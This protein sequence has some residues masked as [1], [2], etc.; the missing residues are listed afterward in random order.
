MADQ[1]GIEWPLGF[2]G[3][4]AG[5]Q[6]VSAL[7]RVPRPENFGLTNFVAAVEAMDEQGRREIMTWLRQMMEYYGYDSVTAMERG[8]DQEEPAT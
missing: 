3:V 1:H 4:P 7:M 2:T 6:V 5:G 8:I